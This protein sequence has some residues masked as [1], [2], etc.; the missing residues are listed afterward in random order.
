MLLEACCAYLGLTLS[1]GVE[2]ASDWAVDVECGTV[3]NEPVKVPAASTLAS[4]D[5]GCGV[6]E[7]AAA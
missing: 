4:G 2:L 1:M 7:F 5:I 6:L 3:E